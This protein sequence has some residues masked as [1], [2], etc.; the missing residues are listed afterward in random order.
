MTYE[1]AAIEV[2]P[3]E[4]AL[5]RR[6]RALPEISRGDAIELF[7]GAA[8]VHPMD[9]ELEESGPALRVVIY[10][11]R[12]KAADLDEAEHNAVTIVADELRRRGAE[13]LEVVIAR[14]SPAARSRLV[15]G[16]RRA[17]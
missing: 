10:L 5:E 14:R 6:L 4:V 9:V 3:E 16:A 17:S 15:L 13:R 7:A 2:V 1:P 12:A 11:P 8:R